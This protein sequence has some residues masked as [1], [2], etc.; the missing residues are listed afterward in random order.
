MGKTLPKAKINEMWDL[1]VKDNSVTTIKKCTGVNS[2]TIKRYCE[3][4]DWIKRKKSVIKK[5]QTHNDNLDAKI[6][7]RQTRT[8]RRM[9]GL[10]NN[11]FYD[12]KG[13]LRKGIKKRMKPRDALTAMKDGVLL[14]RTIL[15]QEGGEDSVI[16]TIN[17]IHVYPDEKKRRKRVESEVIENE[18]RNSR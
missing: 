12:K 8:A 17:I 6:M 1:F 2:T 15:G 5:A 3:R 9:Q 4:P 18:H 14:E 16:R 11:Y 10:G 13:K 7:A